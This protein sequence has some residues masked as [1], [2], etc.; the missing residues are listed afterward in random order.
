MKQWLRKSIGC[1]VAIC[2]FWVLFPVPSWTAE[3]LP[4]VQDV[5]SKY[6]EATGGIEALRSIRNTQT[7]ELA[8]SI[9]PHYVTAITD[10]FS[11]SSGKRYEIAKVFVGVQVAPFDKDNDANTPEFL[12]TEVPALLQIES[13]TDGR[14]V[15]E[16][17]DSVNASIKEGEERESLVRNFNPIGTLINW[18]RHFKSIRVAGIEDV[19]GTACYKLLMTSPAGKEVAFFFFK[20]TGLLA[21]VKETIKTVAG[22]T[23]AMDTA[24]CDYRKVGAVMLPHK[25]IQYK[26][27]QRTVIVIDSVAFNVDVATDRFELPLQVKAFLEKNDV[28]TD[29]AQRKGHYVLKG[30]YEVARQDG[31][32]LV[33]YPARL[34]KEAGKWPVVAVTSGGGIEPCAAG[35][36][37]ALAS[38]GFIVVGSTQFATLDGLPA[39]LN[40][41]KDSRSLFYNKVDTDRIGLVGV[42]DGALN[43][44]GTAKAHPEIKALVMLVPSAEV[45]DGIKIPMLFLAAGRDK[46]CPADRAYQLSFLPAAGPAYF[47][48][49]KE[50]FHY[51][52]IYPNGGLFF[53]PTVAFFR[54]KLLQDDAA[55]PWFDG[56][57]CILCRDPAWRYERKK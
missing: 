42:S 18:Q 43:T 7:R 10:A 21:E 6:I 4:A 35:F 46:T 19:N 17:I 20:D 52:M 22:D 51:S 45:T 29:P 27:E 33:F 2:A 28:S 40:L 31:D 57:D 13:G 39:I 48:V 41:A 8:Q 50:S 15:W 1:M 44:L 12:L 53:E 54:W 24:Y 9:S 37:R 56:D 36:L 32:P 3:S 11:E 38:W 49:H 47:A 55:R 34:E 5:I 26:D 25:I 16:L 14:I 30:P 23:V